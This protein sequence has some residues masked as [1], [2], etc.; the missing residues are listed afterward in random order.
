MNTKLTLT[1]DDNVIRRAKQYARSK[2]RS[3][4]DLV[5]NYLNAITSDT[6]PEE[7]VISPIVKS[8]K[9]SFKAS[10]KFSYKIELE[11]ALA[12]KYMK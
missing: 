2:G 7:E 1:M 12:K 4:S 5:E 9:G 11:K 6:A 8:L 10:K 3:L